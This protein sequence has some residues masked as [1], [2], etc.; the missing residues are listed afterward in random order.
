MKKWRLLLVWTA[1]ALNACGYI[2]Q[3]QVTDQTASLMDVQSRYRLRPG[4]T[5]EL[6]YRLTSDLNQTVVVQPDGYVSLNVAGEVKVGGCTVPD[7]HDLILQAVA[8]KLH[9]PELNLIL[10]EFTHPSVVVAGAVF[11]PSQIELKEPTTAMGAILMAGGFSEEAQSGQVLIF[12]KVN[13][14]VAEITKLNLTGIHKT[15]DLERDM[16]LQAGDM[17]YVPRDKI[18]KLERYIRIVSTG[19]Y[20]NPLQNIQ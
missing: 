5:L 2:A 10:R 4:D 20:F 12:R 11:R 17:I 7:V 9:K 15:R 1:V 16:R 19:V 13:E 18:A 14:E 8:A 6:Q 3:A